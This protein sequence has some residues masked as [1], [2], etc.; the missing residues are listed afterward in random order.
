[1][2]P[3]GGSEPFGPA[4]GRLI[5][6][7]MHEGRIVARSMVWRQ[8]WPEW[9][10]AGNV[11]SQLILAEPE[12]AARPERKF[13]EMQPQFGSPDVPKSSLDVPLVPPR[14]VA[15]PPAAPLQSTTRRVSSPPH[16]DP[17]DEEL[18]YPRRSH[19]AYLAWVVLLAAAVVGLGFVMF[20]VIERLQHHPAAPGVQPTEPDAP[21]PADPTDSEP[22]TGRERFTPLA[23]RTSPLETT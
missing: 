6:Q 7:W 9:R 1:V 19:A 16:I 17:P 23:H 18:Y 5:G 21:A 8:D 22:T 3:Q 4:D 14:A 2:V 12:P 13:M 10:K 11:W 20:K 15:S